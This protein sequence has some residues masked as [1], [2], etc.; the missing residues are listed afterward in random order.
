M[1]IALVLI[2]LV[3]IGGLLFATQTE[4]LA[5]VIFAVPFVNMTIKGTLLWTVLGAWVLGLVLG[6]LA[7]LPGRFGA[8]RR[9]KKAEKQLQKMGAVQEKAVEAAE[10]A[11]LAARAASTPVARGLAAEAA[12]D[13]AATA[14]LADEVARRTT[15]TL[16]S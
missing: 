8:S 1:R 13:A 5:P 11:G 4:N 2:V 16:G 12:D 15:D 3:A 10:T 7:A 6:Y 9:A 14:R